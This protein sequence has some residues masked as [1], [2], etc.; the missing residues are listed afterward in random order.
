MANKRRVQNG[1]CEGKN[2][3][4]QKEK[5]I[6]K[7]EEEKKIKAKRNTVILPDIRVFF[8]SLV[9]FSVQQNQYPHNQRKFSPVCFDIK[10]IFFLPQR[11]Y[12]NNNRL[13]TNL[14]KKR[15]NERRNIKEGTRGGWPDES[16]IRRVG[17]MIGPGR[18]LSLYLEIT[19][20]S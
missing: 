14:D 5:K 10:T 4:K 1:G 12:G 9:R 20:T 8:D 6:E 19:S 13:K 11:I 17:K 3:R 16:Q 18:S 15:N 7:E 2:N